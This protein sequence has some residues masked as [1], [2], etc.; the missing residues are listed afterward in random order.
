MSC[1]DK[2]QKRKWREGNWIKRSSCDSGT[3][4]VRLS[5]EEGIWVYSGRKEV[6]RVCHQMSI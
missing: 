4:W 6:A 5:G 2:E 1:S 3:A